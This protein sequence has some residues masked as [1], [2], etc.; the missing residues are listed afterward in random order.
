MNRLAII[1]LISAFVMINAA[2]V[3]AQDTG[4][5]RDSVIASFI[6]AFNTGKKIDVWVQ[7]FAEGDCPSQI[8]LGV[9]MLASAY[10]IMELETIPFSSLDDPAALNPVFQVLPGESTASAYDLTL[11]PGALAL[12]TADPDYNASS[13]AIAYPFEGDFEAQVRVVFSPTGEFFKGAGLGVRSPEAPHPRI[14]IARTSYWEEYRKLEMF[15]DQ[16]AG[17]ESISEVDYPGNTVYFKIERQGPIFTLAFS[18]DGSSWVAMQQD[19]LFNLPEQVEIVLYI[20]SE[21]GEQTLAR[22]YDFTVA[23]R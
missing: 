17:A 6:E 19:Y 2:P 4:C 8:K 23:Q 9:R 5:S 13:S 11:E 16:G 1:F 7:N 21:V 14:T 15:A 3:M 18:E 12:M 22:F 20:F 10:L